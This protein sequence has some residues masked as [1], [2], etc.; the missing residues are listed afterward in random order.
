MKIRRGHIKS[1]LPV[2]A[3]AYATFCGLA[4]T[5]IIARTLGLEAFGQYVVL[6]TITLFGSEISSG[7]YTSVIARKV[8][9]K[10]VRNQPVGGLL[11][12]CL[13]GTSLIGLVLFTLGVIGLTIAAATKGITDF[14]PY[15]CCLA[16]IFPASWIL[17]N[18][19]A[20][21]ATKNVFG[22]FFPGRIFRPSFLLGTSIWALHYGKGLI[23]L[24]SVFTLSVFIAGLISL[25]SHWKYDFTG[26]RGFIPNAKQLKSLF[27]SYSVYSRDFWLNSLL[28]SARE[29]LL[30][31]CFGVIGSPAEV[32]LYAAASRI[33]SSFRVFFNITRATYQSRFAEAYAQNNLKAFTRAYEATIILRIIIIVVP[34]TIFVVMPSISTL[35]FGEALKG[36]YWV[37]LVFFIGTVSNM[38]VGPMVNIMSMTNRQALVKNP[39]LIALVLSVVGTFSFGYIYGAIGAAAVASAAKVILNQYYYRNVREYLDIRIFTPRIC[40]F[41]IMFLFLSMVTAILL[42]LFFKGIIFHVP[43]T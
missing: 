31:L 37:A 38:F 19:S 39:S 27:V 42:N 22:A 17:T 12:C 33:V 14:V 11:A 20:R 4:T 9:Q 18:A 1:T 6:T 26:M 3:Q 5:F 41:L 8:P 29:R 35:L 43:I 32:S 7:G 30:L 15:L 28:A 36:V 13:A 23:W 40:K 16:A 10:D 21:F 34:M 2:L 25:I 24:I